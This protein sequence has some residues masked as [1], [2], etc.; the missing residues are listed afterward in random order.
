MEDAVVLGHGQGVAI[1]T[2]AAA[3][4]NVG[5]EDEVW[6]VPRF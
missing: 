4:L 5:L 6:H 3:A 1:D 2:A